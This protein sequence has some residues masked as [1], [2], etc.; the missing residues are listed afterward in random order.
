MEELL[1]QADQLIST[2]KP[3][4]EVY[5]AM[6]ESLGRAW[7]DING[8]LENRKILLDLNV[9]Y[10]TRAQE[11]FDSMSALEAA[12]SDTLVPIEIESVK[13]LLNNIHELR[14]TVLESL[15]AAMQAGNM[16]IGNLKELEAEGTLDSRPDRIRL[17]AKKGNLILPIKNHD[18]ILLTLHFSINASSRMDGTIA[19]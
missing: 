17:S 14:R 16:I 10:H 5:A 12:C 9:Q 8:H 1:R 18:V 4:A 19:L 7:N 2:Q 3:R 11:F 13:T 15:M 6:A